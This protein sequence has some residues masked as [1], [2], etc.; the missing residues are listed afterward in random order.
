M[1]SGF[2]RIKDGDTKLD[3]DY[4]FNVSALRN[5]DNQVGVQYLGNGKALLMSAHDA[6]NN[7]KNRD[8]WWY[9]AMWEYLIVDVTTQKVIKKLDFPL[10]ANSRSAIVDNGKAYIAVNDPKADAI[11]I[12]EYDPANDKLTRGA[13][14]K[15]GDND[16]PILFKLK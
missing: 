9:A 1:P 2:F 8:D 5:G 6:A 7:V 12:W 3:P 10:V 15:G 14:I 4:F 16:T 11:Y 13:K